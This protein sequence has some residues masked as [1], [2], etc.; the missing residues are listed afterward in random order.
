MTC[1][2]FLKELTDYLDDAMDSS[3]RAELEEHLQWC[4]N[5]YVVCDTT[6]KTIEIYRDSKMYELPE[7][8][9]TRLESAIISKCKA[10]KKTS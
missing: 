10:K 3:T 4:H 7:D 2:E 1:K 6:K 5:C 9:R 8:L